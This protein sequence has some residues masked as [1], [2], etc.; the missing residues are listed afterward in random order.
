[1]IIGYAIKVSFN[2]ITKFLSLDHRIND[3]NDDNDLKYCGDDDN[4]TGILGLVLQFI[5]PLTIAPSVAMIG[6]RCHEV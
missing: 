3:D 4:E 2:R 1:M 6:L 5:T